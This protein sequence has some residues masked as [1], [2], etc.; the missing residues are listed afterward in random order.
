LVKAAG[1][2]ILKKP[3]EPVPGLIPRKGDLT[4]CLHL[5]SAEGATDN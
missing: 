4:P 5:P 2:S 3:P 1:G